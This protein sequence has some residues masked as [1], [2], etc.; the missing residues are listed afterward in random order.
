MA[1]HSGIAYLPTCNS[2]D[3][4]LKFPDWADV[5]ERLLAAAGVG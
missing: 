3:F 2:H 1:K 4:A 5:W